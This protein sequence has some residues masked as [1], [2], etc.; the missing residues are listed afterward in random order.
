M[1]VV[2]AACAQPAPD[3][4]S[5]AASA[6]EAGRAM[7][8]TID[9]LPVGRG[10]N[11]AWM[12]NVT[13]GLLAQI[14]A[15]GVPVVGFVNQEKI[16]REGEREARTAL[17]Q[18]WVDAGHEL[19]N[20]TY[21]HPSLFSTPL[22]DFQDDVIRGEPLTRA[23]LR[24]RGSAPTD[25]L[26]Y[27][28]H[29]YLN[30]GP[31]LDTKRAFEAWIGARGYQIAP[32]THDNAEY[33]YALAYDR[34]IEAEDAAL[35]ARIADAYIAYM[36]TTA[37][38]FEGLSRDLFGREIPG[39]LLLHANALNADHFNRLMDA[40]RARGYAFVPLAEVL[41]DPAYASEDTYTGRA[42]M[43][44]L[45]RWAITRDIPFT[46]EPLPDGWVQTVAYP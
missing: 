16:D 37:A 31:D 6:P 27:F 23:L 34:A 35:Q 18:G 19:G 14:E 20:H 29:P 9:D 5:P 42:G 7:A 39:V 25:S 38:Y 11:L 45:Q 17:L 12:Q 33:I 26:R 41:Q 4:V 1:L 10:H 36:D 46:S 22:A 2:T 3:S 43:S 40:F 13:R 44:W 24:A 30:V 8:V 21:S 15:S 32:V 28:R